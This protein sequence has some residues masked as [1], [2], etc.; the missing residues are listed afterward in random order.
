[1]N[2]EKIMRQ[3][4]VN[5]KLAKRKVKDAYAKAKR[6]VFD[7]LDSHIIIELQENEFV[8]KESEHECNC[9]CG[10]NCKDCH[11]DGCHC[12]DCH[13]DEEHECNCGCENC[14][15]NDKKGE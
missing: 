1:M 4:R 11:C 15:C 6:K 5:A 3:I 12:D 2:K 9:G 14:H 10:C 8:I 7:F 13:C